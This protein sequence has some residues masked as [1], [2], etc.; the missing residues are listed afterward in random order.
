MP[1]PKPERS[2]INDYLECT[3]I[4]DF[5]N[6][7]I[8][9]AAEQLTYGLKDSLSKARAIYYFVKD[10]IFH[11][12]KISATSVPVTA[13]EVLDTGHGICYAQAHLL[14]ALMRISK[15]PTGLCYQICYDQEDDRLIVHGFNAIYIKELEKWIRLDASREDTWQFNSETE[16]PILLI[17]NGIGEQDDNIIY[18]SPKKRII[19][20][21]HTA[22]SVNELRQILP[23]KL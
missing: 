9:E 4:I 21:L 23:T 18:S 3:D 5:D 7:L 17:N 14:A 16:S 11:S 1:D 15:I 8:E 22:Q 20:V 12:F 13:S 6:P 19:K 10:Q 2:E